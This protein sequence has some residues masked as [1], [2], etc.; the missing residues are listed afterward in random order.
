MAALSRGGSDDEL[1]DKAPQR[2]PAEVRELNTVL[3]T[4]IKSNVVDTAKKMGLH[5]TVD[6]DSGSGTIHFIKT[7]MQQTI[8]PQEIAQFFLTKEMI[9]ETIQINFQ[10]ARVDEVRFLEEQSEGMTF[11]DWLRKEARKKEQREA[12]KNLA[13]SSQLGD[14]VLN[15]T[16]TGD[17]VE[18]AKGGVDDI[19]YQLRQQLQR[20]E[21]AKTALTENADDENTAELTEAVEECEQAVGLTEVLLDDAKDVLKKVKRADEDEEVTFG[22]SAMFKAMQKKID[23]LAG[24]VQNMREAGRTVSD[25]ES[26][27]SVNSNKSKKQTVDIY[28]LVTARSGK[29]KDATPVPPIY[30][31]IDFTDVSVALTT[32]LLAWS[33]SFLKACAVQDNMVH[34]SAHH[35]VLAAADKEKEH[36]NKFLVRRLARGI[37][38]FK[39]EDNST[40]L[41]ALRAI[42]RLHI[43]Y[44]VL[45][46]Q[47]YHTA[48]DDTN[49]PAAEQV[50]DELIKQRGNKGMAPSGTLLTLISKNRYVDILMIMHSEDVYNSLLKSNKEVAKK[51]LPV[52]VPKED[53]DKTE[54]EK[55]DPKEVLCEHCGQSPTAKN[56]PCKG[57]AHCPFLHRNCHYCGA[58]GH[59]QTVCRKMKK[60]KEEEN[61]AKYG[62]G[63][64][65]AQS[66]S[67]K[68][69]RGRGGGRGNG[70][71]RGQQS[72]QSK[73]EAL[74]RQVDE[75]TQKAPAAKA[76]APPP[77]QFYQKPYGCGRG[78]ACENSHAGPGHLKLNQDFAGQTISMVVTAKD[79]EAIQDV[80]K[81]RALRAGAGSSAGGSSAAEP[82]SEGVLSKNIFFSLQDDEE[83]WAEAGA[84]RGARTVRKVSED[85]A[86]NQIFDVGGST[87]PLDYM[88]PVEGPP[89]EALT[90][91]SATGLP[92]EV[93]TSGPGGASSAA[94]QTDMNASKDY[95]A[96]SDGPPFEASTEGS[97]AGLPFEVSTSGTRSTSGAARPNVSAPRD[98]REALQRDKMADDTKWHDA[99]VSE[100]AAFG[101]ND[102]FDGQG[103]DDSEGALLLIPSTT[104]T[105]P[106]GYLYVNTMDH[107][108]TFT[109]PNLQRSQESYDDRVG[110]QGANAKGKGY[111]SCT[112]GD[113]PG[114]R[115]PRSG[116]KRTR[117]AS[118]TVS[119]GRQLRLDTCADIAEGFGLKISDPRSLMPNSKPGDDCGLLQQVE[120]VKFGGDIELGKLVTTTEHEAKDDPSITATLRN[121]SKWVEATLRWQGFEHVYFIYIEFFE[122][123]FEASTS[124]YQPP[125]AAL[126]L[127]MEG[128]EVTNQDAEPPAKRAKGKA[129]AESDEYEHDGE[130]QQEDESSSEEDEILNDNE[131]P[132][133]PAPTPSGV[134]YHED[135]HGQAGTP[136]S[137]APR[138]AHGIVDDVTGRTQRIH[139]RHEG[140]QARATQATASPRP[141]QRLRAPGYVRGPFM[142]LGHR[143][144]SAPAGTST[145]TTAATDD[146][147]NG[148]GPSKDSTP[149]SI[150][151]ENI[152]A[153]S[154][155]DY[156]YFFEGR[157][158]QGLKQLIPKRF[159]QNYVAPGTLLQRQRRGQLRRAMEKLEDVRHEFISEYPGNIHAITC[160][161][162]GNSWETGCFECFPPYKMANPRC[163][164]FSYQFP[165]LYAPGGKWQDFP[166][167]M[168]EHELHAI[169]SVRPENQARHGIAIAEVR[170]AETL[171]HEANLANGA[172]D[173]SEGEQEEQQEEET[174][175]SSNGEDMEI[176]YGVNKAGNDVAWGYTVEHIFSR[177]KY[178]NKYTVKWKGH[179]KLTEE[180]GSH[181]PGPKLEA[182]KA[183]ERAQN[184]IMRNRDGRLKQKQATSKTKSDSREQKDKANKGKRDARA[185]QRETKAEWEEAIMATVPPRQQQDVESS[186]DPFA[187]L[188]YEYPR[189][190]PKKEPKGDI[191]ADLVY[192][193]NLEGS[194]DST[195][196]E[197]ETDSDGSG[198]AEEQQE[199]E[200]FSD[201]EDDA[202][203]QRGDLPVYSEGTNDHVSQGEAPAAHQLAPVAGPPLE[204]WNG[205]KV[206]NSSTTWNTTSPR[207]GIYYTAPVDDSPLAALDEGNVA[208]LP[209][210]ADDPSTA[211][212]HP[213]LPDLVSND[214]EPT[215]PPTDPPYNE[216]PSQLIDTAGD[217][218]AGVDDPSKGKGVSN[219]IAGD[220]PSHGINYMAPVAG[221]L[222]EALTEDSAA[223]LP[224]EV[225]TSGTAGD[226]STTSSPHGIDYM[227]PV[228]GPLFEA[229]TE[230][231]AAGLPLE[232]STSG[233]A[234]DSSTTSS[235]H[236][237]DYMAPVAGPLFEALTEDSAAGLPLEVSTSG[238]GMVAWA[239]R[240]WGQ[241]MTSVFNWLVSSS[242]SVASWISRAGPPDRAQAMAHLDY[243]EHPM[244]EGVA[245][246][247]NMVKNHSPGVPPEPPPDS[248]LC[249]GNV[250]DEE[251]TCDTGVD[252]SLGAVVRYLD[253][254][255]DPV[256]C[257]QPVQT[258]GTQLCYAVARGLLPLRLDTGHYIQIPAYFL[259]GSGTNLIAT[260]ALL[261]G[262]STGVGHKWAKETNSMHSS[263]KFYWTAFVQVRAGTECEEN[264]KVFA[265][266]A[267]SESYKL[268]GR[269]GLERARAIPN[270]MSAHSRGHDR[271]WLQWHQRLCHCGEAVMCRVDAD[272]H[273][274]GIHINQDHA[275]GIC[276]R[277]LQGRAQ[278]KVDH[279]L[280]RG[281]A[282][283]SPPDADAYWRS[284]KKLADRHG[285]IVDIWGPAPWPA[286][287][288][289]WYLAIFMLPHSKWIM[290]KAM[291]K[292]DEILVRLQE[293]LAY[294][295]RQFHFYVK[296]VIHDNEP[297]LMSGVAKKFYDVNGIDQRVTTPHVHQDGLS[298]INVTL[299]NIFSR[300]RSYILYEE[301]PGSMWLVCALHVI[302]VMNVLPSSGPE[303]RSA[304][305]IMSGNKPNLAGLRKWG[306]LVMVTRPLRPGLHKL[307]ARS[308]KGT[309]V[310]YTDYS[311]KQPLVLLDSEQL[312]MI[313]TSQITVL[314]ERFYESEVYVRRYVPNRQG[315]ERVP[316]QQ[317]DTNQP[318]VTTDATAG[319]PGTGNDTQPADDALQLPIA[320]GAPPPNRR[321]AN[322]DGEGPPAN[323]DGTYNVEKIV[324]YDGKKDKYNVKWEGWSHKHNTHEDL[325]VVQDTLA[326]EAW[327]RKGRAKQKG[328]AQQV[329]SVPEADE[330][331][332]AD[333]STVVGTTRKGVEHWITE[334]NLDGG[335][336]ILTSPLPR[337]VYPLDEALEPSTTGYDDGFTPLRANPSLDQVA[338]QGQAGILAPGQDALGVVHPKD[339]QYDEARHKEDH[340]PTIE[341]EIEP[342]P[343]QVSRYETGE[344][345][346]A[347]WFPTMN[348]KEDKDPTPPTAEPD[349][350]NGGEGPF[351]STSGRGTATQR[352][353]PPRLTKGAN[354]A[355]APHLWDL[356]SGSGITSKVA[357]EKGF[358]TLSV[359]NDPKCDADLCMDVEDIPYKT[360]KAPDV[361]VVTPGCA[362][363]SPLMTMAKETVRDKN[364][365]AVSDAA[366]KADR[367][368]AA[369]LEMYYYFRATNP[370]LI[371]IIENPI[372]YMAKQA[373]MQ[374]LLRYSISQCRYGRQQ[375]KNSHIFS[376][377]LLNGLMRCDGQ[378]DHQRHPQ[379]LS[380]KANERAALP[381]ELIE[382][383]LTRVLKQLNTIE[384]LTTA[385]RGPSST[386]RPLITTATKELEQL[387]RDQGLA[388]QAALDRRQ[389]MRDHLGGGLDKPA[390]ASQGEAHEDDDLVLPSLNDGEDADTPWGQA[391]AFL[392]QMIDEAPRA[393][394]V[395]ADYRPGLSDLTDNGNAKNQGH[396]NL[397]RDAQD[398]LRRDKLA[399]NSKW[400]DAMT[401]ELVA[402]LEHDSYD[403]V[404]GSL[405]PQGTKVISTR[406]VYTIKE[407]GL[408]KARL[409]IRG[410]M[411]PS[412]E[413][414]RTT[415]P[416]VDMATVQIVNTWSM[417]HG[418]KMIGFDIKT[419]FLNASYDDELYLKCPDGYRSQHG[420]TGVWKV[421]A[422]IYGTQRAPLLFFLCLREELLK[423]GYE[424]MRA[425]PCLFK[426][427][428]GNEWVLLYAYVDDLGA[429]CANVESEVQVEKDLARFKLKKFG[430]IQRMLGV[431]YTWSDD[432]KRLFLSQDSYIDAFLARHNLKDTPLETMPCKERMTL[433]GNGVL[434][435]PIMDNRERIKWVQAVVGELR[436]LERCTRPDIA[437]VLWEAS[438]CVSNPSEEV[439]TVL[440]HCAGYL[441]NTRTFG[442]VID[443]TGYLPSDFKLTGYADASFAS[444]TDNLKSVTGYAML[445]GNNLM[446]HRCRLT[447]IVCHSSTEAEIYAACFLYK[448]MVWATM[449]LNEIEP[450]VNHDRVVLYDDSEGMIGWAKK[451]SLSPLTRHI[452]LRYHYVK[453]AAQE[454]ILEL[455][456]VETDSNVAD[457]FT[458][459]LGRVK[460]EKFR[461]AL[462]IVSRE[463]YLLGGEECREAMGWPQP[464]RRT[465]D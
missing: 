119:E 389:G 256:R 314:D 395:T 162:C 310:G 160:A 426:K 224:P 174:S 419:A 121:S 223:G 295:E 462:G 225:S 326:Y 90:D 23:N 106:E 245:L 333:I 140:G 278:V 446:C 16:M 135:G 206:G 2:N 118:P 52:Q 420:A 171:L 260:V 5:R 93:S 406:W 421:K 36:G 315:G 25:L 357:R 414:W 289:S 362:S 26:N 380:Q 55:V 235:P 150:F 447:S 192:V 350:S 35:D 146:E 29:Y 183:H 329:T 368:H 338:P 337:G 207:Y 65:P 444:Q 187:D 37:F 445:I 237:I 164:L 168:H 242:M 227:A 112:A 186:E 373:N 53:T 163:T 379:V 148:T 155:V 303:P 40:T 461:G 66:E 327:L 199:D 82:H 457:H 215:P 18:K 7:V 54:D 291:K 46:G 339:W 208:G 115:G 458:K 126:R 253:L 290:G 340:A 423:Q 269:W 67:S 275:W 321:R 460:F 210:E 180:P 281:R 270:A 50:Y 402:Q 383:L 465:T 285:M 300:T 142:S 212:S 393:S 138:R 108:L 94:G 455:N 371:L 451:A 76:A 313:R 463:T 401:A 262:P 22:N 271:S 374:F 288:G 440:K 335:Q 396:E 214:D 255:I 133:V 145:T 247:V 111:S 64:P 366:L 276:V 304:F 114:G 263:G 85:Y 434:T 439:V 433:S 345:K 203:E 14:Q 387:A 351:T 267:H 365:K 75:L 305:E 149:G 241:T 302:M 48:G 411:M 353:G 175:S 246:K 184:G 454:N 429:S 266:A 308:V 218:H 392:L 42:W 27:Q 403:D 209:L 9:E 98:Y 109:E 89:L 179:S 254:L 193:T 105:P 450:T 101:I 182:F 32:K 131:G 438:R 398:S 6:L 45:T 386:G 407:D 158:A 257:R 330:D 418:R 360:M 13:A 410:F 416:V 280:A 11:A 354:E 349:D 341:A 228:A 156:C 417:I 28:S 217:N 103:S 250:E 17:E 301:V 181:I 309:L 232:V 347:K 200:T 413:S 43:Q 268:K 190:P 49:L 364:G 293:V 38:N 8:L 381:R 437:Y 167:T 372:G 298:L 378:G 62:G 153:A 346:A 404:D 56:A 3:Q 296:T 424:Q 188:I 236:G 97:V 107:D 399:G 88:A 87:A 19:S 196:Q 405:L 334:P 173:E 443:V 204:A 12:I 31:Y 264:S 409:V 355:R 57:G 322:K 292:K 170:A 78:K 165:H 352:R 358:T 219:D 243:D 141:G 283:R 61:R 249:P 60:A 252:E 390:E 116:N 15:D 39:I 307:Q 83:E 34:S 306:S 430:Q 4:I 233:T 201:G 273:N 336:T 328:K 332:D 265:E 320:G 44:K 152:Q 397:P 415:S 427:K 129:P 287:G 369:T 113:G 178:T 84:P 144:A 86:G 189:P 261:N 412:E 10:A 464:S 375:R 436:W 377:I 286:H 428:V 132:Q 317:R 331:D 297:T 205:G 452:A 299:K 382:A 408:Y 259:P 318:A 279:T 51:A 453:D 151:P 319:T 197:A 136:T 128:F 1:E 363:F 277:C 400:Q 81:F 30:P 47:D 388:E 68:G 391:Q 195:T 123:W 69:R 226:S 272:A 139:H 211:S 222:F 282:T 137:L 20:L 154:N 367:S 79:G 166:P 356:C 449:V 342:P 284:I 120:V 198:Y 161:G 343:P 344:S 248:W 59:K 124:R 104:T 240:T 435:T 221:P 176:T 274:T 385:T 127:I 422:A 251:F 80:T 239:R 92:F 324:N 231:S 169:L 202:V 213:S 384:R 147:S 370:N 230:D 432:G 95:M 100:L 159:N 41:A 102:Y 185:A 110:I 294:V 73:I 359:D 191:F 229:S 244:A 72:D 58:E 125:T 234:G 425:D 130:E 441:R 24:T 312:V 323:V 325:E 442:K 238:Q 172:S 33:V 448:V 459:A 96:P 376:N 348:E 71:G 117:T 194:D 21:E 258:A 91:N 134:A 157:R 431:D 220:H 394:Q 63:A 361:M 177:N 456:Y 311:W 143:A 74:Q 122:V 216:S 316:S 77:C 99:M 70:G